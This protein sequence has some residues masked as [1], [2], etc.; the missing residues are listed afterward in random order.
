MYVCVLYMN[1]SV[2]IST[3]V[4]VQKQKPEQNARYPLS[5]SALLPQRGLLLYRELTALA[6]L[7]GQAALRNLLSPPNS[8][9]TGK[10]SMRGFYMS[11][12]GFEFR[13]SNLQR[14]YC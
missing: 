14:K 1:Q 4:C 6:R 5:L 2:Q 13:T 7:P 3:Y 8:R 10:C 9:N 12:G 11:A